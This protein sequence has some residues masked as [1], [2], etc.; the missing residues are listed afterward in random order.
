MKKKRWKVFWIVCGCLAAVG[1]FFTLAG[2]MLGGFGILRSRQDE[3]I[4]LRWLNRL[5][6]VSEST[7][8]SELE[9]MGDVGFFT[10]SGYAPGEVN[11]DTVVDF[12]GISELDIELTGMGVRVLPYDGNAIIVDT[13]GCRSDLQDRIDVWQEGEELKVEMEDNGRIRTQNTGIMYISVPQSTYF[14]KISAEAQAGLIGIEG[15][16]AREISASADAGQVS[17]TSFSAERLEAE[18]GVGEVIL[19]GQVTGEADLNCDMGEIQCTLPGS[20]DAYDYEVDCDLGE[21]IIDGESYTSFH[22]KIKTDN[23]SGCKIKADCDLGSIEL[24]FQ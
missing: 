5:G 20:P 7:T 1:I 13:S 10:D 15:V 11:G 18:C 8:Y 17:V 24:M 22:N 4:L 14:Q 6:L 16:N 2:A 23:G 9:D 3:G 21:V 19:E 12:Y